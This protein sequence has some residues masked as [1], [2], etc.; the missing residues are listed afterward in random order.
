MTVE[1]HRVL[2]E[3]LGAYAL[4]QL[5][6]QRWRAMHE[7]LPVCATCRAELEEIAP[8]AGL[9]GAS[10]HRLRLDELDDDTGATEPPPLPP[11]LLAEVRAAHEPAGSGGVLRRWWPAIAAAAVVVAAVAGYT[12]G[13]TGRGPTVPLEP[14]AVRALNP[15][16]DAEAALVP[17]TWGVEVKLTATGFTRGATYAVTVTDDA[18]RTVSAGQFIGT[19][20]DEMRCNLNSSVLRADA[21]S[22]QVIGPDGQVVLDATV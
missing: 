19:G 13:T 22:V 5:S 11:E 8:V 20:E 16:V 15:A 4:G 9:L 7:H 18:G 17:H 6:G 14:V 21:A 12:A 1:S 10:R 2:R 3:Q